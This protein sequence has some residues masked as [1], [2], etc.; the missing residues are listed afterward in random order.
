MLLKFMLTMQVIFPLSKY[1]F[2]M[3]IKLQL[4]RAV[5]PFSCCRFITTFTASD[6]QTTTNL[7]NITNAIF[8]FASLEL[9]VYRIELYPNMEFLSEKDGKYIHKEKDNFFKLYKC[10]YHESRT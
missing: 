6:L 5:F 3:L 4:S 1:A 7:C 10:R 8:E 2:N 9:H